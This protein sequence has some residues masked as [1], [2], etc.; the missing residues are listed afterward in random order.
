MESKVSIIVPVYNSENFLTKCVNS[1]LQQSYKN[2]ELILVDDESPDKS[3]EICDRYAQ[4]DH[5]VVTI[6]KSNGGTCEARNVG[7]DHATGKY[8][9]FADGDDWMEKNCVS[10]L[11]SLMQK[12]QSEM[13]MTDCIFTTR[14]LKQNN[15]DWIKKLTPEQAVCELLYVKTPVGPWNKI[16]TMEVIKK[17]GLKF[18]VPWFGEGLY[19]SVM[20]AQYSNSIGYGHKKI[21]VYRKNNPGSGT[22]VRNVQHGLNALNNIKNIKQKLG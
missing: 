22:T 19:F 6:H 1:I 10:Y 14:N 17:N 7:L 16:Y 21:Y 2:I 4:E 20:A 9:M 11:V 15:K 13:A 12:T 18:D 5:R 3:G 8:L